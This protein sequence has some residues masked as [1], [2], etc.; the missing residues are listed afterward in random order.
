MLRHALTR[1][2]LFR[3]PLVISISFFMSVSVTEV[4]QPIA[5]A[6]AADP[7]AT[8]EPDDDHDLVCLEN[9]RA[10]ALGEAVRHPSQECAL[11]FASCHVASVIRS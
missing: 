8:V 9:E 10:D 4:A 7:F 3:F 11:R 6:E 2:Q 5:D 1:F